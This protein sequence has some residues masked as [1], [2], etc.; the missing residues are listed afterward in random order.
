MKAK[1]QIF[2]IIVLIFLGLLCLVYYVPLQ[3]SKSSTNNT[4]LLQ[5][6]QQNEIKLPQ[7][8]LN[9]DGVQMQDQTNQQDLSTI[10][11]I[12][13]DAFVKVQ[14]CDFCIISGGIFLIVFG[15]GML[16]RMSN[17]NRS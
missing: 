14:L 5:S 11:T 12:L 15:I 2:F 3:I 1:R 6:D 10:T 8:D 7:T 4:E 16:L 17:T 13:G 9:E